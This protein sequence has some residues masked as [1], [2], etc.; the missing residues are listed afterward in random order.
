MEREEHCGDKPISHFIASNIIWSMVGNLCM[1]VARVKTNTE[2]SWPLIPQVTPHLKNN[3]NKNN[4]KRHQILD[5]AQTINRQHPDAVPK[6]LNSYEMD[7]HWFDESTFLIAFQNHGIWVLQAK[8]VTCHPDRCQCEVQKLKS[9]TLSGRVTVQGTGSIHICDS[10]AY[11]S[12]ASESW[13]PGPPDLSLIKMC[14]AKYNTGNLRQGNS[15]PNK[16]RV[17]P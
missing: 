9:V 16:V 11:N 5:E 12:L 10:T 4:K 7:R 8:D 2:C 13:E 1:Q 17:G 3:N 14:G 6:S 15:W